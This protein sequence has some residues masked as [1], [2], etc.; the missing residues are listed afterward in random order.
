MTYSYQYTVHSVYVC[1][2]A[3]T[4]AHRV[5]VNALPYRATLVDSYDV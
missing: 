2:M 4:H 3:R 1:G 5:A